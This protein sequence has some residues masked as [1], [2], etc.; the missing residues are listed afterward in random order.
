[1]KLFTPTYA[2]VPTDKILKN[3]KVKNAILQYKAP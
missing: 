2:I 3:D 1:M